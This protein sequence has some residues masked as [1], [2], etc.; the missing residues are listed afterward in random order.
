LKKYNYFHKAR[1][2][3]LTKK[4]LFVK[5]IKMNAK[6]INFREVGA[7]ICAIVT[8]FSGNILNYAFADQIELF[9]GQRTA[10]KNIS[11]K[12]SQKNGNN[13]FQEKNSPRLTKANTG[14]RAIVKNT[15]L[16]KSQK[17][18]NNSF[19]EKNLPWLA[20]VN[21]FCN[22]ESKVMLRKVD[23]NPPLSPFLRKPSEVPIVTLEITDGL[24]LSPYFFQKLSV[25]MPN[26]KKLISQSNIHSDKKINHC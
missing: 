6:G 19:Q 9:T 10:T 21:C 3:I 4:R 12:K 22:F 11:S 26:G 18:R 1:E 17:N 25:D 15:P 23:L 16:E 2:N 8:V 14:Q 20:K 7:K 24:L 13:S 5:F